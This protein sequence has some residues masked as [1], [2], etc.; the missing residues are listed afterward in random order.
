MRI[1]IPLAI[2]VQFRITPDHI[3]DRTIGNK[4]STELLKLIHELYPKYLKQ[5]KDSRKIYQF[6]ELSD[7]VLENLTFDL[8]GIK[9]DVN[10]PYTGADA[11][12]ST[13][14]KIMY[15]DPNPL[16]KKLE[17]QIWQ[18]T[19]IAMNSL[20]W[21]PIWGTSQ[22]PFSE[23]S[24]PIFQG[25]PDYTFQFTSAEAINI[26][27]RTRR[28]AIQG[29]SA[30]PQNVTNI[31]ANYAVGPSKNLPGRQRPVPEALSNKTLLQPFEERLVQAEEARAVQTAQTVAQPQPQPQPTKKPWWKPWGGKPQKTR[32][33][34]KKSRKTRKTLQTRNQR[35]STKRY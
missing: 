33:N 16:N 24:N 31:I 19:E 26:Q 3:R 12:V 11:M 28:R 21:E 13:N 34:L 4:I 25:E 15:R 30:L 17:A 5:L 10:I 35:Q 1:E 18:G 29:I 9:A 7:S 22:R 27:G 32:K 8:K 20:R 14:I 6:T 23:A 2:Y